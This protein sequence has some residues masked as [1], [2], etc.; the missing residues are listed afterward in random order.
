MV[1]GAGISSA[2][3]VAAAATGEPLNE[4]GADIAA[5]FLEFNF[6]PIALLAQ[7]L[8]L[9]AHL[10]PAD[11]AVIGTGTAA[12]MHGGGVD[13]ADIRDPEPPW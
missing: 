10:Q 3:V 12:D 2:V 4:L 9:V 7:D 8:H 13:I 11:G 1:V 5:G 6:V